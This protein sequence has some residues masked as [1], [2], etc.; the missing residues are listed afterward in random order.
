MALE[1]EVKLQINNDTQIDLSSLSL[2]DCLADGESKTHHLISI[3]YD[4]A[5]LYLKSQGVSLRMRQI[6]DIWL[7]TVKTA[8]V[9]KDGLHQ[10][11]EWE[12]RLNGAEWDL[13]KLRL[14]PLAS[15]I[16]DEAIWSKLE[17]LFTT[18]FIRQTL[19]LTM[20]DGS[21]IELAY[22]YG[23]VSRGE[24]QLPI[25]EIELELKSGDAEQ[26]S[27]LTQQLQQQLGLNLSD[28]SKAQMGYQLVG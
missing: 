20:D 21:Q 5:E 22:D 4:T 16:E 9:V 13:A 10:R 17:A 6:D 24:L 14:T 3:Y 12:D 7:Q 26:L 11:E 15:I 19:Q 25:H 1:Q 28:I 8:G 18:D 23:N 27:K 2:Q